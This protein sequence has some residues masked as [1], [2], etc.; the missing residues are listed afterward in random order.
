MGEPSLGDVHV[1]TALTDVSIGYWQSLNDTRR[2]ATSVFPVVPSPKQS[3]KYHVYTKSELL[4]TVAQKRAPN[5]EAAVRNYKLSQDNF[6]CDVYSV[7]V[8][9]S[10][11]TIANADA[12]LDPEADAARL[13]VDDMTLRMEKDFATAALSTGVWGTESATTASFSSTGL[14]P[15]IATAHKTVLQNTGLRPNTLVMTADGWY[16]GLMNNADIISRLPNDQPKFVTEQFI[17]QVF[18]VDRVFI[19]DS[20]ETTSVEGTTADTFGFAASNKAAL[21]HVAS[22]PGPRTPSAG[23]TFVWSGLTGAGAEGIR[24]KRMEMPWK[25]AMPRVETD[26]AYDFKITGSDLGYLWSDLV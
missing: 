17:A 13:T 14:F 26:A 20:V 2:I 23:Y 24:T 12:V 18:M 21:L 15:K 1:D 3:N 16:S 19:L 22:N 11:Q 4:R 9:V 10:E 6:F 25:D 7:A 8:D 5:T